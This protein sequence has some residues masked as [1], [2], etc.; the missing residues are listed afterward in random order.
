[1]RAAGRRVSVSRLRRLNDLLESLHGRFGLCHLHHQLSIPIAIGRER[2]S[3]LALSHHVPERPSSLGTVRA[4][5]DEPWDSGSGKPQ[6][7]PEPRL[8][9]LRNPSLHA[10]EL[11]PRY[12]D[13]APQRPQP[14][15]AAR[16]DDHFGRGDVDRDHLLNLAD[17]DG[18]SRGERPKHLARRNS[19]TSCLASQSEP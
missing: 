6:A 17:G 19:T 7:M 11:A 15:K 10:L 2:D 12:S 8:G 14:M 16:A 4:R 5:S 18:P 3:V 1:M 9:I 13:L